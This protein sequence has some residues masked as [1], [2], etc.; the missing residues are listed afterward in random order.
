VLIRVAEVAGAGLVIAIVLGSIMRRS[1]RSTDSIGRYARAV[2][3]LRTIASESGPPSTVPLHARPVT[4]TPNVHVL[5]DPARSRRGRHAREPRSLRRRAARVA[6]ELVDRRPLIAQLPSTPSAFRD[7]AV[8]G[9]RANG[10]R[11][12]PDSGGPLEL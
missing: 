11:R 8:S 6:P 10:E 1:R 7:A 3:A 9:D 2:S 5:P 12:H 4:D